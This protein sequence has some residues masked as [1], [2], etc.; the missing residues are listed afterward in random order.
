MVTALEE[1][2]QKLHPVCVVM[3][4]SSEKTVLEQLDEVPFL[5]DYDDHTRY[6]IALL[7]K[8]Q[9]EASDRTSSCDDDI[10]YSTE[11]ILH[12]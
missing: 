6:T 3:Y 7:P 5:A 11:K 12:V 10:S 2:G 9:P 1:T 4:A 8:L